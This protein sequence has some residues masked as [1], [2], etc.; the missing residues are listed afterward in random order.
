MSKSKK[1]ISLLLSLAL[2]ASSV[3]VG[4]L[5]ASAA[6]DLYTTTMTFDDDFENNEVT[7]NAVGADKGPGGYTAVSVTVDGTE[8]VT[9]YGD[10]P[11]YLGC[12]GVSV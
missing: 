5:T 1:I 6:V 3:F 12:W 4:G 2:L 10:Q 9:N 8:V 7:F 11:H